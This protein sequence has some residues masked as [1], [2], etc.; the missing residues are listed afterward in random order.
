MKAG[1]QNLRSSIYVLNPEK[2]INQAIERR[3]WFSGFS[4]SVTYFEH[5]GYWRLKWN[6]IK[7]QIDIE[8]KLKHL[9][10]STLTL[11]LYLLKTQRR[12]RA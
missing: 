6:C 5:W 11:I 8:E 7:E 1:R 12:S 3:D 10:V 2:I 4:N 9:H